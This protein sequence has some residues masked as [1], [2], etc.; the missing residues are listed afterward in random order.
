MKK[1]ELI[2][3]VR[4]NILKS[5]A[6]ADNTKVLHY[7]R[8]E[9]M[10]GAAFA[11]LIKLLA[12]KDEGEIESGYMRDY[13]NQPV[14]NANGLQ[15]ITLP[16]SVVPLPNGGGV[17]YV[18][19]QGSKKNLTASNQ[20]LTSAFMSLPVSEYI[21]DTVFRVGTD[22]AGQKAIVLQHIGDS[23]SRSIRVYDIGLIRDF[24]GYNDNEDIHLPDESY[25]F[26][27]GKVMELMGQRYNDKTNNN[28]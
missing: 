1:N 28:Q 5:E 22:P 13:Y 12:K 7:K 26:L 18:K 10:V 3:L 6:V 2:E 27:M 15:Y 23:I 24:E 20:V 14:S 25:S 21:N 4:G 17:W 11:E 19:P 9:L 16:A 8:V